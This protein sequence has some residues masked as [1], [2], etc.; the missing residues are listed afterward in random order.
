MQVAPDCLC[1]HYDPYPPILIQQFIE[2][3][4]AIAADVHGEVVIDDD[5]LHVIAQLLLDHLHLVVRTAQKCPCL[6]RGPREMDDSE[7]DDGDDG[8][9]DANGS[10]NED[11]TNCDSRHSQSNLCAMKIQNALQ[12]LLSGRLREQAISEASRAVK[13]ARSRFRH[14]HL[15]HK[16]LTFGADLPP[17]HV[18]EKQLAPQLHLPFLHLYYFMMDRFDCTITTSA[19]YFVTHVLEYLSKKLVNLFAVRKEEREAKCVDGSRL[20]TLHHVEDA[21]ATDKSLHDAFPDVAVKCRL[22]LLFWVLPLPKN[23]VLTVAQYLFL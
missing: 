9:N 21:V 10:D 14:S 3:I 18:L 23:V 20:V 11:E 13:D 1:R 22:H 15:V 7:D 8:D 4:K 2:A 16:K 17:F 5:V 19:T 12:T 6:C